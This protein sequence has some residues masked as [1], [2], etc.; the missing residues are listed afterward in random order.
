MDFSDLRNFFFSQIHF[1]LSAPTTVSYFFFLVLQLLSLNE[2]FNS[3]VSILLFIEI[4]FHF[5]IPSP[6]RKSERDVI[7]CEILV[8]ST[9]NLH[10]Q[11]KLNHFWKHPTFHRSQELLSNPNISN[12]L[13]TIIWDI[14]MHHS[15]LWR[16]NRCKAYV[17]FASV[18]SIHSTILI[19]KEKRL[20]TSHKS[21]IEIWFPRNTFDWNW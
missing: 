16:F 20:K 19:L 18:G 14:T 1:A 17:T 2:H 5:G 21:S 15:H 10:I 6:S 12:H 4:F 9:E 7:K 3:C 11:Q 8:P 13:I